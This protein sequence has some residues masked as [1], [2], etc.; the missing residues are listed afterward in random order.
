MR[1]I[2]VPLLLITLLA[3]AQMPNDKAFL[4]VDPVGHNA[5][6]NDIVYSPLTKELITVSDDKSVRL[7]DIENENLNRTFKPF[8]AANGPIGMLYAGAISPDG[9]FLAVAGYSSRNDIKIIDLQKNKIRQV[10]VRH[11]N[12]VTDL[13]FS[14]DG[15]YLASASSD[16]SIIVWKGAGGTYVHEATLYQHQGRVNDLAFSPDGLK[17]VTVSDDETHKL[18]D[19]RDLSVDPITNKNH[20]GAVKRVAAGTPGYLT[21]GEKG[22][23]NLWS[24][25]GGLSRQVTQFGSEVLNM[26]AMG[27]KAFI[28]ADRQVTLDLRYPGDLDAVF[29]RD[30]TVTASYWMSDDK[31]AVA[32]GRDGNLVIIEQGTP[33]MAFTGRGQSVQ[34]LY[35]KGDQLGMSLTGKTPDFFYDFEEGKIVRD[36]SKL[37]GFKGPKLSDGTF[38]FT[39]VGRNQLV[40]GSSFQVNNTTND[41]NVLSYT[42]LANGNVVVGSDR[43]LRVYDPKGLLLKTLSGHNG[44]VL[45]VVSNEKYFFTLGGDQIIKVWSV[46]NLELVYNLFLSKEFEWILWGENGKYTASAG[47]ERFL[48]WQTNKSEDE[49]AELINVSTFSN[50]FLEPEIP[51]ETE[52]IRD[53][54]T[55][56]LPD[57]PEIKWNYPVDFQT[58]TE[59]GRIKISATIASNEPVDK[60]RILVEGKPLASRRG[61]SDIKVIDEFIELTSYKTTIQIFAHTAN[62]KILSEKRVIINPSNVMSV[63]SGR[64]IVDAID[65]PKLYF[66]GVGV[67]EFQNSKFNLT[68]ADDDAES[69]YSVFG[70]DLSAVYGGFVGKK[71]LNAEATK[72][73]ILNELNELATKVT[74]KD[75]IVIFFASHGIN[76]DGLYYVLTH[77]ANENNLKGTCLN[78]NEIAEVLSKLPCRV[79]LFLDTCHSGALGASLMSNANYVKNTEALRKMGSNEVGVVIMSGSTGDESSLESA[80]WQHGVFTLSLIEGIKNK[81]AD[82]KQDGVIYLRELDLFVSD[83]VNELTNG[84]QNPTTQKPSTI[85]KLIIY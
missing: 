18:W 62:S 59:D 14:P 20:L 52:V 23:V 44:Q 38:E 32:M 77:D 30:Q 82:L 80:E 3:G 65:K 29:S 2:A 41:G 61:V 72:S 70:D 53:Q 7:W 55:V 46:D 15:Q 12:V 22:I 76:E 39:R 71:I 83:N 6:V 1:F 47:G 50:K 69:L 19:M 85:S 28:S 27:N 51:A 13:E 75:Q 37:T 73:N 74:P 4:I 49:L 35:I 48:S 36:K 26:S 33:S 67:S 42:L 21:G 68:Y 16:E 45:S 57:K 60:V 81:K 66:V 40:F 11:N 17:L 34:R 8:S 24:W 54:Q 56:Q 5:T 31:L 58:T 43:T 25:D 9:Q 78:W 64:T 79:V 63:A 84:R 10:L